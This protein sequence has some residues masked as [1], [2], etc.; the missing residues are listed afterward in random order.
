M[1]HTSMSHVAHIN[2]SCHTYQWDVS[3]DGMSHDT[4]CFSAWTLLNA[5][6]PTTSHKSTIRPAYESDIPHIQL[7]RY[8]LCLSAWALL[9]DTLSTM[10]HICQWLIARI[11]MSHRVESHIRMSHV[12]RM[13][14][15]LSTMLHMSVIHIPHTNESC[16]AYEWVQYHIRMSYVPRMNESSHLCLLVWKLLND[17]LSTMCHVWT[18]N[19]DIREKRPTHVKKRPSNIKWD[20][21]MWNDSWDK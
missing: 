15:T 18:T 7:S 11:R 13:N 14:V 20:L 12:P 1:S 16:P 6:L 5:T 19:Q 17:M 3:H 8:T 21:H 10:S 4:L 2:Q 9:N